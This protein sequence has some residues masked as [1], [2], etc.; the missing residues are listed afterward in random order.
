MISYLKGFL[1]NLFNP[2]VSLFTFIDNRSKVN[3]K[4]KINRF[5]K[6]VNSKIGKY[7]Y[8]GV[9]SWVIH[10]DVGSFCSIANDVYI[11][12]AKHSLDYLSTSP[13]FT[14][15]KNGTGYSWVDKSCFVSSEQTIIGNDVWIGYRAIIR[16]GV[17]IGNGA[18]V[19]AGAVV[20]KDVPA[21]AVIAGVPA[22]VIRYRYPQ[23][24][25]EQLEKVKWWEFKENV[26]QKNI[27]I[28]Q[29]QITNENIKLLINIK[30]GG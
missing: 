4:G 29:H 17:T 27:S 12:L 23:N 10:A 8:V 24:M 5:A 25:I 30:L 26:L 28:F 22:K 3:K 2:A 15:K 11:G 20:T 9:R 1:S 18:I 7:S 19:G 13:I 6:V 16:G 14:E 21:Y